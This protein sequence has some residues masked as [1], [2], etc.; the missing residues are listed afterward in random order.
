MNSSF[1]PFLSWKSLV[2]LVALGTGSL[3]PGTSH[4]QTLINYNFNGLANG[5]LVGQD[6][7]VLG[8]AG[9]IS[10]T[11]ASAG[12]SAAAGNATTTGT[13]IAKKSFFA[14]GDVTS[15][16][17]VTL[18]FDAVRTAAGG[19][20]F[21]VFGIGSSSTT[22]AYFG[23]AANSFIIR[24]EGFGTTYTATNLNADVG[25]WFTI[26]SVW[27]LSTGTA[28]LFAKNITDGATDF[29]QLTFAGGASSVSLGIA[30]DVST[31]TTGYIRTA[32]LGSSAG[33]LDNLSAVSVPEPG[34]SG[35]LLG[36][37]L[38]F[39]LARRKRASLA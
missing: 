5:D 25:D 21:S 14:A 20:N 38:A 3:L 37:G 32:Q 9:N 22:S 1:L 2:V 11:V 35:L 26:Q 30:T 7:W 28:T 33:Y 34:V 8:A 27:N 39:V 31:W 24:G 29:T 36:A 4:G 6:G 17:T 19:S 12:G 13:V 23:L 16:E 15:S 18:T 10:P